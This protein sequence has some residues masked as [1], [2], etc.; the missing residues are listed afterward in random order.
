[1]AGVGERYRNN[2]LRYWDALVE[3]ALAHCISRD[4]IPAKWS[5][6]AEQFIYILIGQRCQPGRRW[7][8]QRLPT[9]PQKLQRFLKDG[10]DAVQRAL[11]P[12]SEKKRGRPKYAR[13]RHPKSDEPEALRQRQRRGNPFN[14]QLTDKE[15]DRRL[16]AWLAHRQKK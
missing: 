10:H 13:G 1:V 15:F 6:D 7:P 3:I 14:D 4:R 5:W 8:N 11:N 12:P 16:T 9:D 2:S